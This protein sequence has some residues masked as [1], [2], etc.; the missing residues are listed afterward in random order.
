MAVPSR[1]PE[2]PS[3]QPERHEPRIADPG[4]RDLSF[5]DWRAIFTRAAKESL[6][7]NVPMIA[8]AL[9]YSSFFAIPSILLLA[10]GAFTLVSGPDTIRELIDRLGTFMPP[11]AAQ[12]VGDSL[13]RLERTPST[14]VVLT[15]VGFALAL[16]AATSAMN[17]YMAALNVAYDRKDG[18]SFVRKR[19]LALAMVVAVGAAVIL[20]G[21][22]VVFGPYVQRWIGDLVGAPGLVAWLW[23]GLQWPVLILG[24]LAAFAVLHYFGPDVDH[25]RWQLVTPGSVVALVVWLVVSGAFAV[26][27]GLFDSY[28]KAWGSLSAVI[29]TMTWLW[30]TG[31]A[32]LFGGEVNAEV[33]RSRELRQGRP[34]EDEVLAPRRSD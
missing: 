34:A 31:A 32:L 6:D 21:V 13:T 8:S 18:R 27:T 14:G 7:D 9:A 25:P 28:N 3:Q 4:L 15:I 33:E 1:E 29:V 11:D 5:R 23:W 10:V 26:Y 24:L 20:V 2:G 17:T 22:L 12:L 19:L 30:L 16:W